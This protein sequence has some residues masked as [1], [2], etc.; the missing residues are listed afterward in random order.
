M[1]H[2]GCQFSTTQFTNYRVQIVRFMD[3]IPCHSCLINPQETG[4]QWLAIGIFRVA[5]FVYP[6][7]RAPWTSYGARVFA[8]QERS[9]GM[10]DFWVVWPERRVHRLFRYQVSTDD[11]DL[12]CFLNSKSWRK[13]TEMSRLLVAW[14]RTILLMQK[15]VVPI[16][17]A[18]NVIWRNYLLK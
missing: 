15:V 16:E 12:E 8:K 7:F 5:L 4:R 13:L 10:L 6:C 2:Q 1:Q 18:Y 3:T 14:N 17:Y 9:R 11:L